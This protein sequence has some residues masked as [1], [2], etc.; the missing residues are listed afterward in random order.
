[1]DQTTKNMLMIFVAPVIVGL[2]IRFLVGKREKGYLLSVLSALF[3]G[4]L[5]VYALNIE[6]WGN[7]GYAIR[8]LMVSSFAVGSILAEVYFV[9]RYLFQ[10]HMKGATKGKVIRMAALATALV[11]IFLALFLSYR[12]NN[13]GAVSPDLT[14]DYGTDT[15]YTQEEIDAAAKELKKDFKRRYTG[16]TLESLRYS[17]DQSEQAQQHYSTAQGIGFLGSCS[18]D[19]DC[20]D[21]SGA[22]T[23]W[24]WFL[25]RDEGGEWRVIDAG[26]KYE[27]G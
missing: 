27:W 8:A 19:A 23:D 7:E 9:F 24:S 2:I 5:W 1:M 6:T 12:Y 20:D 11:W 4:A 16:C 18:Y 26:P 14:L 17:G 10:K 21:Y 3:A 25:I 13:R 22:P 15:S